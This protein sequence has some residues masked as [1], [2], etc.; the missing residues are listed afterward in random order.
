MKKENK[1]VATEEAKK[2]K[3]FTVS[4]EQLSSKSD[5]LYRL[6]IPFTMTISGSVNE[7]QSDPWNCKSIDKSFLPDN[8]NFIR[9]VKKHI[10]SNYVAM[11]FIDKD[12]KNSNI[13]YID[14]NPNIKE[15][16]VFEDICCLDINGAYWQTALLMGV[17]SKEIYEEGIK[18]DKITR[19]ASLG[20]L[21]KRKEV[22]K[23]DGNSF[24]HFETVR[25]YETENIWFAMCKRISDIMQALVK[26]LG[27][28]FL[29]YWVDG[30]YFKRSDE[31]I[32]KVKEYLE[33]CSYNC[34]DEKAS[35]VEFFKDHFTVNIGVHESLK[36]F[37]W[38]L[39]K[40][41]SKKNKM[42][43]SEV[44]RLMKVGSRILKEK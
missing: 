39:G 27:G 33:S 37:W 25:S 44:K 6:R 29:F 28:D 15:G 34:K 21:A 35:Q 40:K 18:K 22:Y 23:F 38:T 8:M 32:K 43:P 9:K 12:Y 14:V 5:Y 26:D 4:E 36:T 16:D 42:S 7:L 31:N 13:H 3:I 30:I 11:K 2:R 10:V 41:K 20:S 24:T 1:E 19:L 17:I